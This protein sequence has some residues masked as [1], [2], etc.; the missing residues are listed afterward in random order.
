MRK[1][2]FLAQLAAESN[3]TSMGAGFTYNWK[4]LKKTFD[5][6]STACDS[7]NFKDEK[8][9]IPDFYNSFH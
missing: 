2:H 1:A 9:N 8:Y 4:S 7:N 3:F 6:F 5:N